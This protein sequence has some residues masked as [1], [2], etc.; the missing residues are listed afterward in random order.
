[1]AI[2]SLVPMNTPNGDTVM[3]GRESMKMWEA[4]GWSKVDD[5]DYAIT[6]TESEQQTYDAHN[7]EALRSQTENADTYYATPEEP[8]APV[9]EP[10]KTAAKA[11][12]APAPAPLVAEATPAP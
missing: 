7:E 3:V 2:D 8:V 9:E 10:K 12:P 1:M 11:V 5:F 6:L 4:S